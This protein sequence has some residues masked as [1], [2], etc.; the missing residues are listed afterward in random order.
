MTLYK[1]EEFLSIN[2][3]ISYENWNV[4]D[5][6][7]KCDIDSN[8]FQYTEHEDD[9]EAA[10]DPNNNLYEKAQVMIVYII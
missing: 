3:E 9:Y 2:D 5:S 8:T 10:I 7:M 4:S 1:K 6:Y